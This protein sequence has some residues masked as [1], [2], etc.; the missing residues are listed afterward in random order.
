LLNLIA[1]G[2]DADDAFTLSRPGEQIKLIELL[3]AGMN[4]DRLRDQSRAKIPGS[5]LG[6]ARESMGQQTL[7]ELL[8]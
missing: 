8:D 3:D 1:Q 2:E 7:A 6:A 4:L 5:I